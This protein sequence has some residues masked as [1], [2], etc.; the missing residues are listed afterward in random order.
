ME[1][2]TATYY[3]PDGNPANCYVDEQPEGYISEAEWL[4]AHPA[5]APEPVPEPELSPGPDYEKRGENWWQIRFSKKD[6]LLLC[7]VPQVIK[8]EAVKASGN[9]AAQAVYTL[10]MASE[11]I[12]VTDPATIQLLEMLAS[13]DAGNVLTA[14]DAARILQGVKYDETS[15]G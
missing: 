1:K 8:L 15:V 10:L 6:F 4:A 14:E 9:A 3:S 13:S 2:E 7:G 5:P 12:D 11:Y